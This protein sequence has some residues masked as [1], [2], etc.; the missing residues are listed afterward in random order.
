MP[1]DGEYSALGFVYG[2]GSPKLLELNYDGFKILI[3]CDPGVV[4]LS[5]LVFHVPHVARA[6]VTIFSITCS[7][8]NFACK[9]YQPLRHR[10]RMDGLVPTGS[11]PQEH[12]LFDALWLGYLDGLRGRGETPFL[13]VD[14]NVIPMAFA[15]SIGIKLVILHSE[16]PFSL[17]QR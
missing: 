4:T 11:K 5:H 16:C 2:L 15:S 3:A 6:D 10:G 12:C 14:V 13:E 7:D 9:A 1:S 8:A 17:L